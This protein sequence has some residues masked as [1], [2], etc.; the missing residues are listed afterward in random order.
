MKNL[1]ILTM[2][3]ILSACNNS[4]ESEKQNLK[5]KFKNYQSL[6]EELDRQPNKIHMIDLYA[7]WCAP[8]KI[9]SPILKETAKKYP[10][11]VILTKINID[12]EKAV[13]S[14]FQVSS[15][16][17]VLFYYQGRWRNSITGLQT[18]KTYS[19]TIEDILQT[20]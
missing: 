20:Q 1:L 5:T 15:I 13:T 17:M 12:L 19:D 6:K 2:F 7:D 11:K 4:P 16:P 14:H 3:I 9:L 18:P 8:C 10:N